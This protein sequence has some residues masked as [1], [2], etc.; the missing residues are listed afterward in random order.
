M[1]PSQA[2][3]G[4]VGGTMFSV[5]FDKSIFN[6]LSNLRE[7]FLSFDVFKDVLLIGEDR[8]EIITE[9]NVPEYYLVATN[10]DG[11]IFELS[12]ALVDS[13]SPI[14]NGFKITQLEDTISNRVVIKKVYHDEEHAIKKFKELWEENETS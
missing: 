14:T 7:L 11:V 9:R 2:I 8:I 13:A 3:E 6:T 1:S 12:G 4:R 10:N 5:L